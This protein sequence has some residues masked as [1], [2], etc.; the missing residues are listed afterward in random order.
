M[1]TIEKEFR[2]LNIRCNVE[3]VR[4]QRRKGNSSKDKYQTITHADSDARSFYARHSSQ[5]GGAQLMLEIQRKTKY[6]ADQIQQKTAS[7]EDKSCTTRE[8]PR[9]TA[10]FEQES[11]STEDFSDFSSPKAQ[12]EEAPFLK[13]AGLTS[14]KDAGAARLH[15]V[16]PDTFEQSADLRGESKKNT[17]K[18]SSTA[19]GGSRGMIVGACLKLPR[20]H[21]ELL[22]MLGFEDCIDLLALPPFA[23]LR[24]GYK[25]ASLELHPD[26]RVS[27]ALSGCNLSTTS[28]QE[29]QHKYHEFLAMFYDEDK[30][31]F[32][33]GVKMHLPKVK[34]KKSAQP[35]RSG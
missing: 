11:R 13:A 32:N 10:G 25:K 26:K 21:R 27:E 22:R 1:K 17:K 29:F 20:E 19:S 28:F 9:I 23:D 34:K 18:S 15:F 5:R 35:E 4:G 12:C 8:I 31:D 7:L 24:R 14:D 2:K 6:L 30:Q 3:H 16:R 33:A